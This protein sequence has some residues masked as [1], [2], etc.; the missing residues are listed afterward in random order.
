M[1]K[2]CA[3]STKLCDQTKGNDCK[4]AHANLT[5]TIT[6]ETIE[7]FLI[8]GMIVRSKLF[9]QYVQIYFLFVSFSLA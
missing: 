8:T 3:L 4:Y 7:I 2:E 5:A 9:S 6:K 1:I